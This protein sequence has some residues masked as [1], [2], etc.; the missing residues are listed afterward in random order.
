MSKRAELAG[1]VSNLRREAMRQD[2]QTSDRNL[3]NMP[4]HMAD[5][6]SDNWEQE[7]TLGL[8]DKDMALLKEIDDALERINDGSYGLCLGLE[9]PIGKTR[10]RAKP[11]AKY[12]I[13]YAEMR[14]KGLVD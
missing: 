12:C 9:K 10:L 7:F 6:G 1:D 13:E 11:W 3:S 4:T 2:A 14:E 5:L 8:L